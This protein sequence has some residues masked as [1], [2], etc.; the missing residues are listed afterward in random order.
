MEHLDIIEFKE[1]MTVIGF[2]LVKR[3][4]S[5]IS[6]ASKKQYLDLV[7][8]DKTGEVNAKV[9]SPEG[10]ASDVFVAGKLVKIKALVKLWQD[11]PQL[12]IQNYRIP[13]PADNQNIENFVPTAPG[14]IEEYYEFILSRIEMMKNKSMSMLVRALLLDKME[15][16]KIYPAAKSNHHSVRSGL[17]YHEYRMLR[18]AEAMKSVYQ[19]IDLDLLNAGIILHDL[20]KTEEMNISEIGLVTEYTPQGNLLGHI[21]MGVS[22]IEKKAFELGIEDEC[23][24]LLKHM[25]LSHHYFPE[26]G[27]P[28][29]PM[30]LEAELLHHIDM[31]DARVYDFAEVYKGL[32]GGRLSE[33]IFSLDRR[34]VYKPIMHEKEKG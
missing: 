2:Y 3:A 4:E 15:Q 10:D 13:V 29:F 6:N 24:L 21:A 1:G 23:V 9:W 22:A 14:D 31:V 7:L 16:F 34:R 18:L 33:P 19:E 12:N 17:I 28:V 11:K 30:F 8:A 27:S 32:E 5:K 20:Y 25:V 26:F